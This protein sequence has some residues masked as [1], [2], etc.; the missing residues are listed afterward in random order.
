MRGE[1]KQD[2]TILA[3][4]PMPFYNPHKIWKTMNWLIGSIVQR[5]KFNNFSFQIFH[6]Y[7]H[8]KVFELKGIKMQ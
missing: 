3:Q 6:F 2:R 4:F 7:K 5:H 1:N 8:F